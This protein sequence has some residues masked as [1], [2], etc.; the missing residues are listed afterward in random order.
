MVTI[1]TSTRYFWVLD[2]RKQFILVAP[3][4]EGGMI[5]PSLQGS[6][7]QPLGCNPFGVKRPFH[8]GSP[9]T[10]GVAIKI[11]LIGGHHNVRNCM[12]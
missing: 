1:G 9:K 11:V 10:I 5:N 3:I 8:G 7:S 2:K 4:C 6:D 12:Y